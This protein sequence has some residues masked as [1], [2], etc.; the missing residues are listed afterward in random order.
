M[1]ESATAGSS[2]RAATTLLLPEP[3]AR[4]LAEAALFREQRAHRVGAGLSPCHPGRD[5]R[6]AA[7]PLEIVADRHLPPQ[8]RRRVDTGLRGALV[9]S[10]KDVRLLV[11]AL[12]AIAEM[13]PQPGLVGV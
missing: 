7:Q 13:R 1:N 11:L 6:Q 3:R 10:H 2:S 8:R 12:R 4:P 5:R 9:L